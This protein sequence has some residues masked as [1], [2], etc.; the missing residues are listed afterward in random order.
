MHATSRIFV[1]AALFLVLAANQTLYGYAQVSNLN[2][3][4]GA[5]SGGEAPVATWQNGPQKP[6]LPDRA[7]GLLARNPINWAGQ[8]GVGESRKPMLQ[9]RP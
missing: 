1:R 9:S 8:S 4:V 3:G 2:V 5:G 6:S 7:R